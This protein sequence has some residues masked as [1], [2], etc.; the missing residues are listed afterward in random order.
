M[1]RTMTAGSL[2]LICAFAATPS[3][4]ETV[5]YKADLSAADEVP[6]TGTKGTGHL[7]ATYDTASKTLSYKVDYAD[8]S[9]PATMAHFHGPAE[10][11]H[12]AG[13][14]V[15]IT[16][17]L[18]SPI[19]GTATLTDSQAKALGDGMMY[20]NVHTDAHKSGEIRG[21]VEKGS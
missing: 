12:N 17:A 16:G 9:G 15:P 6:P 7:T 4:A 2:A 21:Q 11:G 8:L 19:S 3:W 14:A 10:K 18:A 20:F 13:V 5:T 1:I